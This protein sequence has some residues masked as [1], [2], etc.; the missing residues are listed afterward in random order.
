MGQK[1]K[2]AA[3]SIIR[4]KYLWTIVAF[5]AIVG[6]L[7]A[8]S[9]WHHYELKQQNDMLRTEIADY[10]ARYAADTRA[11]HE[12][13][14]SQEAIERVARVNLYM[15]TEDEDVYVIE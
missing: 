13:E 8:N 7:D 10:E 1:L 3:L 9:F 12:L 6:F 4:Q 15:K 11:L 5:I 14:H 2:H